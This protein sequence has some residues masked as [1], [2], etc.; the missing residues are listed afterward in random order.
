MQIDTIDR[1]TR[2]LLT[3]AVRQA[4]KTN[5]E[6]FLRFDDCIFLIETNEKRLYEM[7]F[8][9]NKIQLCGS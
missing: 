2:N 8:K 4:F 7:W 1:T 5:L 3:S 9:C 6:L